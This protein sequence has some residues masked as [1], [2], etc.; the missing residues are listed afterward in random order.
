MAVSVGILGEGQDVPIDVASVLSLFL[1][2]RLVAAQKD[3]RIKIVGERSCI[4]M[5]RENN[6][7]I[8]ALE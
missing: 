1:I 4:I 5:F 8:P 3:P 6:N 2:M 7:D